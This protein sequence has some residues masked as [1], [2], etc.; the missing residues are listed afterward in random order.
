MRFHATHNNTPSTDPL[1]LFPSLD[2][3]EYSIITIMPVYE[4]KCSQCG[5]RQEALQ[6]I[7]DVPLTQCAACGDESLRKMVSAAGFVLKG[8]G[9]YQTDFKDPPKPV[10][11]EEEQNG[12]EDKKD[13]EKK[14]TQTTDSSNTGDTSSTSKDSSAAGSDAAPVSN[15]TATAKETS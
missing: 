4:Y 15:T 3:S 9:W 14:E 13:S 11:K 1:R 5:H 12:S 7:S 8:T 2:I 10:K 6:K